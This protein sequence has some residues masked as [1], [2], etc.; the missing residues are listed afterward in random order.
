M[1]KG[2]PPRYLKIRENRYQLS[3]HHQHRDYSAVLENRHG[4]TLG[5][6]PSTE[7]AAR[8]IN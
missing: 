7:D 3:R 5:T 1:A 4:M 8:E 2:V 6:E